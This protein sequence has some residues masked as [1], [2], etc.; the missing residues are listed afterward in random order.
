MTVSPV[1]EDGKAITPEVLKTCLETYVQAGLPTA[2]FDA[3]QGGMQLP[4]VVANF[5]QGM[6]QACECACS[7]LR[8]LNPI[9]CPY[10]AGLR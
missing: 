1:F 5:M 2:T 10:A 6:F 3:A 4:I 8:L 9:E 7:W